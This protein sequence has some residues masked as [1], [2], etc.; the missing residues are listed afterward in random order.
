MRIL[1]GEETTNHL[2]NIIHP[3]TQIRDSGMDL[4]VGKIYEVKGKG[5]IDFGGDEREDEEIEEIE[6]ILR[7][8]DDDYGWWELKPGTYLLEYNEDIDSSMLGLLQP[9]TRLT[10]NAATHPSRLVLEL[11]LTPLHVG[12]NGISIK[13]NSRISRIFFID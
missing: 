10:R 8:P 11:G 1:S 7:D 2:K 13:E 9:L 3:E 6:P 12:S 4:T 5:K